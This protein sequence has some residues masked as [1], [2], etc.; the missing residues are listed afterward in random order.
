MRSTGRAYR[1]RSRIDLGEIDDGI[2]HGL[3]R[4]DGLWVNGDCTV[5][6]LYKNTIG[7]GTCI[8]I[9]L[10]L[11][12]FAY[13]SVHSSTSFTPFLANYGYHPEMQFKSPWEMMSVAKTQS[14]RSADSFVER[15]RDAHGRLKQSL[16]QARSVRRGMRAAGASC[17]KSAIGYGSQRSIYALRGRPKSLTTSAL[18]PIGY[19]RLSMNS[20]AY[21]PALPP[22]MRIHNVFHVSP[23]LGRYAPPIEGQHPSEPQPTIIADD[24]DECEYEVERILDSKIRYWK[25]YY[26]VQWAG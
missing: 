23:L 24:A 6:S 25:L 17:L 1:S 11:A 26:H 22:A 3:T 16:L 2:R 18:V 14:E 19:M 9:L 13:N 10:P 8:L 12:E 15:L 21:R 7:T 5:N 4:I 20:R